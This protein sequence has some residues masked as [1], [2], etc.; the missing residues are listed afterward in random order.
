MV[1]G[2]KLGPPTWRHAGLA[3][4]WAVAVDRAIEYL[5]EPL[6]VAPI[7][8]NLAVLAGGVISPLCASPRAAPL[9]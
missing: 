5:T 8:V 7:V 9:P 1:E 3:S 4:G 6:A 2:G